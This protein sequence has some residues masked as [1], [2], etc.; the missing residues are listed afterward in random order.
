M[1]GSFAVSA[2][3][4]VLCVLILDGCEIV[5]TEHSDILQEEA[6]VVSTIHTPSKHNMAVGLSAV[7]FSGNPGISLGNGLQVSQT[8]VPEKFAVLFRCPH[9]EFVIEKKPIY[10]RFQNQAGQK[11]YVWYREIYRTI[12]REEEHGETVLVNRALTK[13]EFVD[14]TLKPTD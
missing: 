3:L 11:V 2:I 9:G 6:V 5:K 1:K 7:D 10:D 12:Y 13:Y 8:T 14:A 4:A